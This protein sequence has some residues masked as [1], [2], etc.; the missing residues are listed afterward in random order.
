MTVSAGPGPAEISEVASR[1]ASGSAGKG[2]PARARSAQ[3]AVPPALPNDRRADRP[4]Q[5]ERLVGSGHRQHPLPT[6]ATVVA[7]AMVVR[8][9]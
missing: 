9:I 2:V 5:L 1:I 6:A 3:R 8:A 7:A 4:R